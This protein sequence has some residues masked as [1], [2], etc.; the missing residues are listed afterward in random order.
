MLKIIAQINYSRPTP[1]Y[2]RGTYASQSVCYYVNC[3]KKLV[4]ESKNCSRSSA[5]A[6]TETVTTTDQ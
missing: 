2:Q 4:T 1:S 5:V 6:Y 3:R